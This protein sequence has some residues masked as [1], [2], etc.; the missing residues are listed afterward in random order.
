MATSVDSDVVVVVVIVIVVVVVVVKERKKTVVPSHEPAVEATRAER[1]IQTCR[2]G[3]NVDRRAEAGTGK[4]AGSTIPVWLPAHM[5]PELLAMD[6]ESQKQ[7]ATRREALYSMASCRTQ[8]PPAHAG[9]MQRPTCRD[10]RRV[11]GGAGTDRAGLA[12]DNGWCGKYQELGWLP[13]TYGTRIPRLPK[14]EPKG[15]EN[16]KET[17]GTKQGKLYPL[18]GMVETTRQKASPGKTLG[19]TSKIAAEGSKLLLW[20]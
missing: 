16:S 1:T 9:K 11:E 4:G 19:A 5:V 17:K 20:S 14:V 18:G 15:S 2:A 8:Y 12:T 13:A 3:T 6:V 7:Q 10:R